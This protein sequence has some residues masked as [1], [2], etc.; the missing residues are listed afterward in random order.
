MYF[1]QAQNQ[2]DKS[3]EDSEPHA[4]I[5][6]IGVTSFLILL[7]ELWAHFVMFQV[8]KSIG[9]FFNWILWDIDHR[10]LTFHPTSTNKVLNLELKM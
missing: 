10:R 9:Q 6:T 1:F 5:F 3:N 7:F 4:N 2:K 8:R